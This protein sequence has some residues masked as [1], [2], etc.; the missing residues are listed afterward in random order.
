[1]TPAKLRL[2]FKME[3]GYNWDWDI[4]EW[5]KWLEEQLINT[6]SE[7]NRWKDRWKEI[8]RHK[9]NLQRMVEECN[10]QLIE[11]GLKEP[12]IRKGDIRG[13]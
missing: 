3:T 11:A 4:Q 1:M 10:N 7:R 2:K 5:H 13:S 9:I 12:A 8:A 6:V